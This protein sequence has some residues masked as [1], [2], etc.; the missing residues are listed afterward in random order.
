MQYACTAKI[1]FVLFSATTGGIQRNFVGTINTK[2]RCAYP[3]LVL[4]RPLISELWPLIGYALCIYQ[5][6]ISMLFLCNYLQEVNKTFFEPSI[7]RGDAHIIDLLLGRHFLV[8]LNAI[9]F[10]S[11]KHT[12]Y[13]QIISS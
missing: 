7:P 9:D 3:C 11:S 13:A 2:K 6:K 4:V 12:L 10:K 8:L 5:K 1:V